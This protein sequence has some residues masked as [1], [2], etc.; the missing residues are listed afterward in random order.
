MEPLEGLQFKAASNSCGLDFSRKFK[1]EPWNMWTSLLVRFLSSSSSALHLTRSQQLSPEAMSQSAVCTL[2]QYL[3]QCLADNG[4]FS[5]SH[6]FT[7]IFLFGKIIVY[8]FRN[9]IYCLRIGNKNF[10][11][12]DF[13]PLLKSYWET[14]ASIGS[15]LIRWGRES[16]LEKPEE[17]WRGHCSV[18]VPCAS[19]TEGP[20]LL[21][22]CFAPDFL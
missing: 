10:L 12:S 8:P 21:H 6:S 13:L 19:R 7:H 3:A 1:T 17:N 22:Q 14:W 16:R 9:T 18:H 5:A 20:E 11:D 4:I 2:A 15:S